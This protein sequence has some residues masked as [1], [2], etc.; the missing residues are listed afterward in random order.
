MLVKALKADESFLYLG[1]YF[2]FN[3]SDQE[4]KNELTTKLKEYMEKIDGLDIHPRNK[5]LIY[6]KYVLGKISWHLT[7]S[8]IS[9]TWI[10]EHLDNMV[11]NYIRSW[12]ELPVNGTLKIATL[13]KSKYGLNF[14]KISTRFTQC[15]VTF[16]NALKDSSNKNIQKLHQVTKKGTNIQHDSY[17]ST[18]DAIKQIRARTE[19][20]IQEELA[21]QSLV[22][23]SIWEQSCAKYNS[24]WCKVLDSLPRNLYSFTIR[25]L[26]NCLANG[27]NAVKWGI[28]TSAKCTFCNENQ[29]LQHVVSTCKTSLNEGRWNWR[30]DSILI[31]IARMIAKI[32][33]VTVYCDVSDS[34]FQ[35]PSV[36][37]GDAKRPDIVIIKERECKVLELTV[38]FETNLKKNSDRK[39]KHYADLITRLGNNYDVKYFDLSMGG[40]GVIGNESKGVKT[41]FEKL[42]LKKEESDYLIRKMINVCLRSTYYIFCQRNKEWE[43]PSLLTW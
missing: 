18:R 17:L 35:N 34:E 16:R 28:A 23:R 32:P 15:Q 30:H 19:T 39:Q 12:L 40:I 13:S 7:V 3:M 42:G 33:G 6:Q 31:N 29:T 5:I 43:S 10:K 36:I 1:R 22:I 8:K 20:E 24:S 4:H 37:T 9:V 38:G 27:T 26:S 11:S 25:Y 2:D 21:T 41:M 14:I